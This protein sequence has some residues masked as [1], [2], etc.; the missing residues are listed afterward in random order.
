MVT[1]SDPVL[2][3]GRKLHVYDTGG[4]VGTTGLAAFWHHGTPSTGAPPRPLFTAAA[5][6]GNRWLSHDRPGY[7]GHG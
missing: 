4:G 3:D 1:E 6:R 2:G 7:G 5:E